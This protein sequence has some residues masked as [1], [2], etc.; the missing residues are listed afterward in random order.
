MK[1]KFSLIRMAKV[2]PFA[3]SQTC[4]T[5]NIYSW[6]IMKPPAMVRGQQKII[7]KNK[8]KNVIYSVNCFFFFNVNNNNCLIYKNRFI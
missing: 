5:Y 8:C 4:D 7:I 1:K 6:H 3:G 2:L